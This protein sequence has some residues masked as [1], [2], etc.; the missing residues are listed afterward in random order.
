VANENFR[1]GLGTISIRAIDS[2]YPR[3]ESTSIYEEW[4]EMAPEVRGMAISRWL[5]TLTQMDRS[6]IPVGDLSAHAVWYGPTP[7]SRALNIGVSIVNEYRGRGI[8]A[9]A[10]RLLADE[11]HK[12]GIVRVE[13]QT[14]VENIAEQKALEK[15]GFKNEGTLRKAQGRLDG[16]HDIQVW[17]HIFSGQIDTN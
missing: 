4:G 10:Q 8:G 5:I 15:A 12:Q 3:P 9:I 14:D 17:S 13:A 6:E 16:L 1:E 7:G 11:L 2:D